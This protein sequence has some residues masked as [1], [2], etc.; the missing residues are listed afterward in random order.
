MNTVR[1]ALLGS[2]RFNAAGTLV[3]CVSDKGTLHVWAARGACARL[4]AAPAAAPAPA[5]CAFA[6]DGAAVGENMLLM[7]MWL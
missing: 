4:C 6:H 3:C 1:V 2:I 5:R 7:L